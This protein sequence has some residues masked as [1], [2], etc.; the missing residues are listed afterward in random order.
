MDEF[1]LF[2]LAQMPFS[3]TQNGNHGGFT[4]TVAK[5]GGLTMFNLYS[6][7]Q[8]D[9]SVG[10]RHIPATMELITEVNRY[11]NVLKKFPPNVQVGFE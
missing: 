6:N 3:L 4:G 1:K 5:T 10:V 9:N 7:P 2:F 11:Q 8:E